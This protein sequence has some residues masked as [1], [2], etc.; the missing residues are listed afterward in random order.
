LLRII[1]AKNPVHRGFGKCRL[2]SNA[3]SPSFVMRTTVRPWMP[4]SSSRKWASM[5]R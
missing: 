5:S 2:K 3:A 4:G 1:D